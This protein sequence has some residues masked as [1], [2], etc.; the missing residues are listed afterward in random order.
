MTTARRLCSFTNIKKPP[1]AVG[2]KLTYQSPSG[3]VPA[4]PSSMG[5]NPKALAARAVHR[6]MIMSDPRFLDSSYDELLGALRVN[7]AA[8]HERYISGPSERISRWLSEHA[9]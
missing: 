8:A 7:V 2:I 3:L 4:P 9:G 5:R 1:S 6:S